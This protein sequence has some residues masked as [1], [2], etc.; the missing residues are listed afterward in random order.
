MSFKDVKNV[1]AATEYIASLNERWPAR[2]AIMDLI[3]KQVRQLDV[4]KPRVL[5][6]CCGAGVLGNHLLAGLPDARYI[7]I[8]QSD[9]LLNA[10]KE[11]LAPFAPRVTL[12]QRDLNQDEWHKGFRADDHLFDA[13]VSMQSLHDLGGEPEVRRIYQL[14]QGLLHL[15]GCFVNADLIVEPGAALPKN[16]GRLTVDRHL[17]LLTHHGY[18]N[19]SCI[20]Q[21][22][23]FGVV[24][25]KRN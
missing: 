4:E 5:E 21:L 22:G 14:A 8:D 24:V 11:T 23:G 17:Q 13:I 16:P 7:G 9:P 12:L 18:Q 2:T 15:N 10:A 1:A 20:A 3:L 6:F 25:G 19:V